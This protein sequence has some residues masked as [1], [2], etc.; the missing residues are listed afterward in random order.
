MPASVTCVAVSSTCIAAILDGPSTKS[1]V[2]MAFACKIRRP[3][4]LTNTTRLQIVPPTKPPHTKPPPRP[5]PAPTPTLPV[6][7]SPRLTAF[8]YNTDGFSD[9]EL[10]GAAE[11]VNVYSGLNTWQQLVEKMQA[12]E[13]LQIG[14]GKNPHQDD[15]CSFT[16]QLE[17]NR[18]CKLDNVDRPPSTQWDTSIPP[19]WRRAALDGERLEQRRLMPPVLEHQQLT[20]AL[21]ARIEGLLTKEA[22]KRAA[23]VVQKS[24]ACKELKPQMTSVEL[25][26]YLLAYI[27]GYG[28]ELRDYLIKNYCHNPEELDAIVHATPREHAET[29]GYAQPRRSYGAHTVLD[30]FGCV[31]DSKG[32]RGLVRHPYRVNEPYTINERRVSVQFD[33]GTD[34]TDADGTALG[35]LK[36]RVF[37][38]APPRFRAETHL[39]FDFGGGDIVA[40]CVLDRDV[41]GDQIVVFQPFWFLDA[42]DT[43][44]SA[45]D[46]ACQGLPP[47]LGSFDFHSM[48]LDSQRDFLEKTILPSFAVLRES[49]KSELVVTGDWK[50][51]QQTALRRGIAARTVSL[52]V[53]IYAWND[54]EGSKGLRTYAEK[55]TFVNR[56]TQLGLRHL[57][58][59]IAAMKT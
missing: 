48:D 52:S 45:S 21:R 35:V 34:G 49:D 30:T 13:S 15:T 57:E 44:L 11:E 8:S 20:S 18:G 37:E 39:V 22:S 12:F 7:P 6:H 19:I 29:A 24:R 26:Q 2:L 54:H 3:E 10:L 17:A 55:I 16:Q 1:G 51:S 4:P 9:L 41:D 27:G 25:P 58:G 23:M 59:I 53:P 36:M 32:T 46:A 33:L 56:R 38:E 40:A 50:V 43:P 14:G 28:M 47:P 5:P 42:N 31:T